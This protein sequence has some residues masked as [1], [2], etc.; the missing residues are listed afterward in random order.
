MKMMR[1][2]LRCGGKLVERSIALPKKVFGWRELSGWYECEDCEMSWIPQSEY[3]D[4]QQVGFQWWDSIEDGEW[5]QCPQG[6]LAV[7]NGEL[8]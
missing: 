7:F 5:K 2:C 1:C 8:I 4:G 6:T 3:E